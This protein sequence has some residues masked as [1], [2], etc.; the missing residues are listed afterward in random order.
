MN[1]SKHD[2]LDHRH[3]VEKIEL[4]E[5]HP[6]LTAVFVDV[7][8]EVGEVFSVKNYVP[9]CGVFKAIQ[10]AQK[11]GLSAARRTDDNDAFALADFI[12]DLI[13]HKQ[14]AELFGEFV[15]TYQHMSL[16]LCPHL[17]P[18]FFRL[19]LCHGLGVCDDASRLRLFQR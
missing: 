6:D 12:R 10:A 9:G 13:E 8:F 15:Y 4:L 16:I 3:V 2:I 17:V 1:R 5:H 7:D 18:R 19:F 14:I 11:S